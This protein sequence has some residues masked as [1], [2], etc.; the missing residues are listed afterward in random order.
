MNTAWLQTS[1]LDYDIQQ[2]STSV[3]GVVNTRVVVDAQTGMRVQHLEIA[4]EKNAG[5]VLAAIRSL[6][7]QY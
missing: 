4:K 3:L 1:R 6:V 2:I 7:G 5:P